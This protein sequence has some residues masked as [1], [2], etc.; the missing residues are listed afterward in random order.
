MG[1]PQ[2]PNLETYAVSRSRGKQPGESLYSA[3]LRKM[4]KAKGQARSSD[5]SESEDKIDPGQSLD[6][7]WPDMSVQQKKNIAGQL[8]E[9]LEKMRPVA[10]PAHFIGACD[11]TEIRDTRLYFTYH[12]PPCRDEKAFNEFLLS[13]LYEHTPSLVRRAFSQRLR[14]D[15]RVVFS[16]CDLT[17]RNILVQDGK[18]QGLVDWEDIVWYPEY[19]EYVKI[20]QR[21]VDKDW[22]QYAE[23]IFPQLYQDELADFIAI[24][25]WQ[26]S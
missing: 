11:G 5:E 13:A 23:D 12:S 1:D 8:R 24:S 25:K 17:L 15:H 10:P 21:T 9:M 22:K 6:K 26:N 14:T 18:I 2:N 3:K 7:L 4:R 16:H 20:F 19:W